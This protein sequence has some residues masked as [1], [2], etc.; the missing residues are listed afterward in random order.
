MQC[1]YTTHIPGMMVTRDISEIKI[2]ICT[3]VTHIYISFIFSAF[4]SQGVNDLS[5]VNSSL[6]NL[7]RAEEVR[8]TKVKLPVQLNPSP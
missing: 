1:E 6:S 7:T 3:F 4:K 8:Y 5:S 2:W